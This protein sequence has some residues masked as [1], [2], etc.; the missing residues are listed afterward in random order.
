[1]I[2][3]LIEIRQPGFHNKV[4][5]GFEIMF[6]SLGHHHVTRLQRRMHLGMLKINRLTDY[7]VCKARPVLKL[8][9]RLTVPQNSAC[10]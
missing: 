4:K 9:I 7:P 6:N 3:V 10:I 1:M 2:E 8:P 5:T